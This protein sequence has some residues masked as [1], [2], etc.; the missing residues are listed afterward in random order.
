VY[1]RDGSP[2]RGFLAA[3]TATGERTLAV[4][5]DA[6]DLVTLTEVDVAGQHVSVSE[7]GHFRFA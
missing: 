1:G 6:E 7:E 3:R 4:T 5:T 2:E